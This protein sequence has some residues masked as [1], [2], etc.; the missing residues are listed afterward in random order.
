[1]ALEEERGR[2]RSR[3][4]AGEE[5]PLRPHSSGEEANATALRG[6]A[7]FSLGLLTKLNRKIVILYFTVDVILEC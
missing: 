2:S 1:M 3:M 6:S 7:V 4:A 5:L